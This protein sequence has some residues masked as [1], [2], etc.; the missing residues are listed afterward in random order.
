MISM[1]LIS[2]CVSTDWTE[3]K[4]GGVVCRRHDQNS[5]G[6]CF[7]RELYDE[8]SAL[9][10]GVRRLVAGWAL[11]CNAALRNA[12]RRRAAGWFPDGMNFFVVT[13][14]SMGF[15]TAFR[16]TNR[17]EWQTGVGLHPFNCH[18][19]GRSPKDLIQT[20]SYFFVKRESHNDF[21]G[22]WFPRASARIERKS[23]KG[24]SYAVGTTKTVRGTVLPV[25]FMM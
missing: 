25:G 10:I 3:I 19:R 23:N 24:E 7:A 22:V 5:P 11:W 16:M 14:I 6:D 17:G 15:F 20:G 21:N 9:M 8:Y 1:G 13:I 4:Q 2:P 18:P 12:P